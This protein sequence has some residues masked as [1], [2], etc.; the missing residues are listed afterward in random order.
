[1]CGHWTTQTAPKNNQILYTP[2]MGSKDII[3][4]DIIKS[5]AVDLAT[6][7][8]KLDIDPDTL[9]LLDTEKQRIED[10]RADLVVRVQNKGSRQPYLL[11]IEIQNSNDPTMPLRMLRY[12]T[13]IALQW[14]GECIEQYVIYIGKGKL[15]MPG[16]ITAQGMDYRYHILDM[17][18]IDCETLIEQD[19]PEALILAVLCDFKRK[20]A[21]DV[22]NYIVTRLKTLTGEDENGFRKHMR[23][24]AILSDN[25]NLKTVVKEAGKMLTQVDYRKLP[26]FELGLEQGLEQ[27]LEKGRE[28]GA[29]ANKIR[30]AH[31]LLGTL[32]DTQIAQAVGLPLHQIQQLREQPR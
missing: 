9:E 5:L 3:S 27:G 11:H 24:L 12:Y 16:H 29:Y 6:I 10:R 21:Q 4:K 15:R 28:E 32:S 30:T 14:P 31:N 8:L 19:T 26:F 18:N 25:R 2:P 17:R 20:P 13:D 23:M 1:M 22:V 7:L